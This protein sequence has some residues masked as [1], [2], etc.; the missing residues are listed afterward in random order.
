MQPEVLLDADQVLFDFVRPYLHAVEVVTGRH[1]EPQEFELWDVRASL[2]LTSKEDRAVSALVKRK[3]FCYTLPVIPG[4]KE[5]VEKLRR[6]AE[7]HIVTSPWYG[8]Y[9][10]SER[11]ASLKDHFGFGRKEVIQTSEK[12]IIDG[13]IIIDDKMTTLKRWLDRRPHKVAVLWDSLHNRLDHDPRIQRHSDWDQLIE[14]YFRQ[15][16]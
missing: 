10:E 9:W 5:G 1:Y 15:A 2:K 8:P 16:L 7:I 14:T 4:A 6:V 13:D 11:F 3:G 12:H